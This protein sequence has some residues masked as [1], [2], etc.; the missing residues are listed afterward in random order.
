MPLSFEE[1]F[2]TTNA[3]IAER[4]MGKVPTSFWVWLKLPVLVYQQE[5]RELRA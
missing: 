4:S 1:Q 2:W 3:M 5:H